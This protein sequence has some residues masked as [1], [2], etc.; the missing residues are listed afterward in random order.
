MFLK[1]C[2]ALSFLGIALSFLGIA[3][4]ETGDAAKALECNE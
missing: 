4:T 3:L 1:K 2:T